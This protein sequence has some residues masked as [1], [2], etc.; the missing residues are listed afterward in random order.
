[1]AGRGDG[2]PTS[3]GVDRLI[4]RLRDEGVEE[5]R[6]RAD[7]IISEAERRAR[8]IVDDAEREARTVLEQARA[9]ARNLRT[10]ADDALRV[11]MRDAVLDLK[12]QLADRFAGEVGRLVAEG[13]RDPE[14]LKR[15]IL[16]VAGRAR[17]DAGLDGEHSAEVLLPRDVIGLDELRKRPE[18]LSEGALSRF[19]LQATGDLLRDGVTFGRSA[20]AEGGI[21]I[22]LTEHGI[23]LDLSDRAVAGVILAHLQPRFRAL[24]EGVVR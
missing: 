6:T 13:M 12:Q 9:D 16:E 2:L 7:E 3:S 1:M 19:V 21:R 23:S 14:L 18:E 24:L 17:D 4:E 15:L 11:A 5:G 8:G 20:G 22:E 10:A